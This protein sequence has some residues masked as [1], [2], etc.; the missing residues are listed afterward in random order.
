VQKF[1]IRH[2]SSLLDFRMAI[3]GY[4]IIHTDYFNKLNLPEARQILE[5][6]A[7][8]EQKTDGDRLQVATN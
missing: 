6:V 4:G 7:D 3:A 5:A 2:F 8:D 1:F